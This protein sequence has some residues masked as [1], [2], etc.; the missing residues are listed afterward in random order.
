MSHY[1]TRFR[2]QI[3]LDA[4][5]VASSHLA[6]P[7]F[8]LY[9]GDDGYEDQRCKPRFKNDEMPGKMPAC[10]PF[11]QTTS[12]VS[13]RRDLGFSDDFVLAQPSYEWDLRPPCD[14]V[15]KRPEPRSPPTCHDAR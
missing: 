11:I 14:G 1:E 13:H 4:L 2:F 6:G 10:P 8:A 5:R 12:R 15:T 9:N 7:A 3:S